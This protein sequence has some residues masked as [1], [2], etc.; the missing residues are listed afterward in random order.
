MSIYHKKPSNRDDQKLEEILKF[1]QVYGQQ[2]TK[3]DLSYKNFK[4]DHICKLFAVQINKYVAKFVEEIQIIPADYLIGKILNKPFYNAK[5][6]TLDVRGNRNMVNAAAIHRMF[7]AVHSLNFAILMD[8]DGKLKHFPHLERLETP[9]SL[10]EHDDEEKKKT[11]WLDR[12]F[13]SKDSL[14]DQSLKQNRQLKHLNL[15]GSKHWKAIERV[16]K[17]LPHLESL[18]IVYSYGSA[19]V[20]LRFPNMKVFKFRGMPQNDWIAFEFEGNLEEIHF[21]GKRN[22]EY[23]VELLMENT[24]LRKI[25]SGFGLERAQFEKIANGLPNL[26]EFVMEY[27]YD[28]I[29]SFSLIVHFLQSAKQVKKITIK[30]VQEDECSGLAQL[31]NEEWENVKNGFLWCGFVRREF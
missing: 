17:I 13:A 8:L 11:S 23:W 14:L 29:K 2:I 27:F 12:L 5:V 28:D 25:Y 4:N 19:T 9:V 22:A 31:L 6:V 16:N 10:G 1:L 7:P 3:L 26:E 21:E 30:A 24:K 20:P 15:R 18:E